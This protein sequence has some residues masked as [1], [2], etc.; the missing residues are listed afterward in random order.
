M[1]VVEAA[2]ALPIFFLFVT[3]L[4]DLG[5][6]TL[7]SN[8]ATNAAR[9]GARA[10]ILAFERA[11]ALAGDDRDVVV[12][13]VLGHLPDGTADP[14][15]VTIRCI[16]PDDRTVPCATAEVEVD[17]I[18]VEVAWAWTLVTPIA[19]VIGTDQ[20]AA[21]ASA[22]MLI[23]GLPEELPASP[24]VTTTTTTSTTS[25][26][27]SPTTAPATTT[28]TAPACE[29]RSIALDPAT[30]SAKGNGKL[31]DDLHI[32]ITTGGGAACDDLQLQL[33]TPSGD[34]AD[35]RCGCGTG[36]T[37]TWVYD[38]NDDRTWEPGTGTLRVLAGSSVIASQT[39]T[40]S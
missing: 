9:D 12:E 6:W 38:K 30:P 33:V 13:A 36:P 28:T 29:V 26:G 40:V 31:A 19:G 23:V 37:F 20:G 27:G 11:D 25:G 2:F 3:G 32:T 14:D 8:Q 5:M 7:N 21:R 18:R 22:T 15:D 1:T 16:D 35:R 4:V 34:A 24:Q 17:R 10:G 39:F